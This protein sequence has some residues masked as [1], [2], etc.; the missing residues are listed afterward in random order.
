MKPMKKQS[1]NGFSLMEVLLAMALGLIVVGA[2]VAMFKSA[3]NV[4]QTAFSRSD[5]Q[6]NARGAL[7]IIT[8]DLSQASIGIPQAGI[9]LP[10]GG[11]GNALG[12][13][14]P[15]QC[16]LT[17]GVYPNNLL[18][19]VVPFDAQGANGTDA[20]TVAYIDNSWPLTN[21]AITTAAADGSSITVNT[22][23]FDKSGNSVPPSTQPGYAYNDPVYGS[24]IGDAMMIFNQNGYAVATVT[25]VS[26]VGVLSLA[27]GDPLK[28][29]QTAAAAGNVKSL[30]YA[31]CVPAPP[32]GQPLI[33]PSTS[34]A[35]INVVTYFIQ[36]NP[37]PDG[38][39]G[40]ADDYPVLMRQLSAQN[41]IPLTD[42][43]SAMNITYD[44]YNS[45]TN[46]YQAALDGTQVPNSSEIRRVN[47][48]L[49]L[50]SSGTAQT[51][52]ETYTVS[53]SIAP[54][55]LSFQ[56]RY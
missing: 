14:G 19:P 18:A 41:A 5:M 37:G 54:R 52:N 12:A 17:N 10:S 53:T 40:T 38:V 46:T 24:K 42:Y 29:N 15:T 47:I 30:A 55:D 22:G 21:Q 3:T 51:R 9:T 39:L 1:A 31:P 13:C 48:T 27:Q 49:T 23:L 6:Q 36:M 35:R 34:A 26:G 7:A 20:I 45:T 50:Q 33:C 8:R 25:T 28:F 2:G 43:A 16:Y 4:T 44:I 11:I 56:N 32:P